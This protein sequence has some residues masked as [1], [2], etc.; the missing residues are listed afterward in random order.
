MATIIITA[1]NN[2]DGYTLLSFSTP[3]LRFKNHS[4]CSAKDVGQ[5]QIEAGRTQIRYFFNVRKIDCARLEMIL[6]PAIMQELK[7][8]FL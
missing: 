7:L 5:V 2:N 4:R 8:K 1:R 3:H 6:A